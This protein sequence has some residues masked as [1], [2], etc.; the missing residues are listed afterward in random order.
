VIVGSKL[1]KLWFFFLPM[2][3]LFLLRL[4][5]PRLLGHD[6]ALRERPVGASFVQ[7]PRIV[8]SPVIDFSQLLAGSLMVVS[9]EEKI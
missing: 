6:H 8:E 9:G 2:N 4:V 5:L 3:D 1:V 7:L